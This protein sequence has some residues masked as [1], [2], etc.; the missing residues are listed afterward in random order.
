VLLTRSE[1]LLTHAAFA[2]DAADPEPLNDV[3]LVWF[4]T[5]R[6]RRPGG[7]DFPFPLLVFDHD[8]PQW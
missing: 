1:R 6:S 2:D 5:N 7:G 8:G 4:F 3:R